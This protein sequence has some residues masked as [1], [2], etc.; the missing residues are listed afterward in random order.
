MG[1]LFAKTIFPLNLGLTC[2]YSMSLKLSTWAAQH[3]AQARRIILVCTVIFCFLAYRAGQWGLWSGMGLPLWAAFPIGLMGLSAFW[4]NRLRRRYAMQGKR[5]MVRRIGRS[6]QTLL[7]C[8]TW[9][10]FYIAGGQYTGIIQQ[11]E[12][13][14]PAVSRPAPVSYAMA[15]G[16]RPQAPANQAAAAPQAP[17]LKQKIASS[18]KS[19]REAHQAMSPGGQ[20]ALMLLAFLASLFAAYFLILL[21]CA[22]SCNGQAFLAVVV[23]LMSPASIVLGVF[24]LVWGIRALHGTRRRG[25]GKVEVY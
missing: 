8:S 5:L 9:A 25:A 16:G 10:L 13:E 14:T 6:A 17:T 3:P 22:L 24:C 20:F 18:Y 1:F 7:L 23:G 4:V 11:W 12:N 19:R 15:V 21:S 2:F